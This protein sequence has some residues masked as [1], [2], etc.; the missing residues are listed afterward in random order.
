VV[1]VAH[2]LAS[3]SSLGSNLDSRHLSKILNGRHKQRS[4]QHSLTRQKNIYKKV[5][6]YL[7]IILVFH[8]QILD[9]DQTSSGRSFDLAYPGQLAK[10]QSVDY[11]VYIFIFTL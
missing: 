9:S 3:G 7:V 11:K 5:F 1:P 6:N 2:L 4:G 8:L 10:K